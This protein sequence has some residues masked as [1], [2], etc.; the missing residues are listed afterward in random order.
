MDILYS[1]RTPAY[2]DSVVCVAEGEYVVEGS[3]KLD[4][5]NDVLGTELE[6]EDYSSLGGYLIELLDDIPEVG[7]EAVENGIHYKVL[8]VDKNRVDKVLIQMKKEEK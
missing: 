8:S 4:D 6:S 1:L 5:L 7:E 3:V 2:K